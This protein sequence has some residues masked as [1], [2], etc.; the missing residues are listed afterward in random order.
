MYFEDLRN[1]LNSFKQAV[2]DAHKHSIQ[3][4]ILK[5]ND[6]FQGLFVLCALILTLNKY[7]TK[8]SRNKTSN[9]KLRSVND[10]LS[11][12]SAEN[13]VAEF[14]TKIVEASYHSKTIQLYV[15]DLPI[16]AASWNKKH[17]LL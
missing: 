13:F 4:R 12:V 17:S 5:I 10:F 15:C 3:K 2:F 8:S 14:K 11:F 16:N 7:Y 9:F 1:H 6:A